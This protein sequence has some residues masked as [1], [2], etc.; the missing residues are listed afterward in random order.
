MWWGAHPGSCCRSH[1]GPGARNRAWMSCFPRVQSKQ[2]HEA[3]TR[4][5][6]QRIGTT[7]LPLP[8]KKKRKLHSIPVTL[9]AAPFQNPVR[10]L[11]SRSAAAMRRGGGRRLP[12]SSLAPSAAEATPAL[13]SSAIPIRNLNSAFWSSKKKKLRLL[14][15]RLRRRQPL[16]QPPR[17]LRRRGRRCHPQLLR[18]RHAGRRAPRRQRLPRP[19]R[20]AP[21][22]APLRA[23]HPGRAPH[24]PRGHRLPPQ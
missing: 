17:F 6:I 15:P 5:I 3:G 2:A 12:K 4:S 13:D 19:R 16:Q 11:V 22:A 8:R 9:A 21:R 7:T 20:H 1:S 14:P 24:P 18:P 10:T 23:R